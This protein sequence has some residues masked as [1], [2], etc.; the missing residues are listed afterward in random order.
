MAEQADAVLQ[1]C[2]NGTL[3]CRE[4]AHDRVQHGLICTIPPE[5]VLE[6]RKN[7]KAGREKPQHCRAGQGETKCMR[8]RLQDEITEKWK[9]VFD[10]SQ[11]TAPK[12]LIDHRRLV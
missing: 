7:D 4:I 2:N 3:T 11:K 1:A 10:F 6:V 5:N 9:E 8:F 12:L